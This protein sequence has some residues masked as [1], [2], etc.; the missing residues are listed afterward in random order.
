MLWRIAGEPSA[1]YEL[2]E[3]CDTDAFYAD[4]VAWA[5]SEGVF[6]GYGDGS[7]FGPNDALTRE[8][9]A[10]VLKNSAD[11]LGIGN[12]ERADL[13]G[14]PD[15]GEVSDWAEES[16]AWAVANGVLH[17]FELEDGTRELQPL[18]PCTRAE[19][20]ALLMNLSTCK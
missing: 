11:R 10:C 3:D 19:M 8:Q 20:A 14:Y 12:G 6:H 4:A 2:P 1:A 18:R 17:G 16:L 5:L 15:A 13:S 9:A 7:T